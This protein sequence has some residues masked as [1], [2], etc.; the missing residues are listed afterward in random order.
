[1]AVGAVL[2][3]CLALFVFFAPVLMALPL[4]PEE[5][6]SRMWLTDC[7]RPGAE[8]LALPDDEISQGPPPSGWCWI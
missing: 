6:R 5:W 8:T 4:T 3:G 7:E 2:A 1:V